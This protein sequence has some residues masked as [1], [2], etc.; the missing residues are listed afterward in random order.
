M[1]DARSGQ[2]VFVS[3]CLLNQN[4]RYLGGAVC[5]GVVGA[6]IA[7]YEQDGHTRR[8]AAGRRCAHLDAVVVLAAGVL[9]VTV[10][11]GKRAACT[12]GTAVLATDQRPKRVRPDGVTLKV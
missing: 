5:P 3:H 6:A 9:V 8:R 11:G 12:R 7:P 1:A 4:T 10:E 2:V